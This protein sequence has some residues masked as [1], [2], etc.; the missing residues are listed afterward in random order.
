MKYRLTIPAT[1]WFQ[2][3]ETVINRQSSKA[4]QVEF[5]YGLAVVLG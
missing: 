1:Q 5:P 2:N 3:C 4:V